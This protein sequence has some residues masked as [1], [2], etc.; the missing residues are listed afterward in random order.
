M[1]R[2]FFIKRT[3]KKVNIATENNIATI[4]IKILDIFLIFFIKKHYFYY[5]IYIGLLYYKF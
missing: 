4:N 1:C 3:S 2:Q 5:E